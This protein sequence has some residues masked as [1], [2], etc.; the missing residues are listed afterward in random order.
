MTISFLK[1]TEARINAIKCIGNRL[2]S[3]NVLL[4]EP[5]AGGRNSQVYRLVVSGSR[6]YA[7]KAYFQ[8]TSDSRDRLETEF[9]GL[10]FLWENG[11]RNVPQPIAKDRKQGCAIYEYIDGQHLPYEEITEL[12]IDAAVLF[13]GSLKELNLRAQS[14]NL[15]NASEACFSWEAIIKSLQHRM[16]RLLAQQDYVSADPALLTFLSDELVPVYGR[17]TEWSRSFFS[18]L[19]ISFEQELNFFERTISPSDF[20]F[21]N[22]L[23]RDNGEIVFL[24]FEYFGWDD[25]AKMVAD[26]LLHPAMELSESLKQ[27]FTVGILRQFN[28]YP[29][30]DLRVQ[31]VY[32]LFGL[33]WC[34]II[35]NEFL[36]DDFN[37]RHFAG[38][39]ACDKR[40]IQNE[41]LLKARRILHRI[42]KEYACFPYAK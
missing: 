20:G 18:Q 36:L 33:K 14:R 2:L 29:G 4:A 17:V 26:F 22:A 23:R 30:L 37:R 25:P 12:E 3:E 15:S 10:N 34:F 24:D 9:S 32:P 1:P 40:S 7:L 31:S 42:N 41:Q 19:G 28:D 13:L 8:H 6:S 38:V 11:I 27:K 39:A 16:D 21:H 35:L 5:I